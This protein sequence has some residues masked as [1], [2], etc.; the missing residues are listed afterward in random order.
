MK[1]IVFH[2]H[3]V[4]EKHP[5]GKKIASKKKRYIFSKRNTSPL[6]MEA[7]AQ[8]NINKNTY[9]MYICSKRRISYTKRA[10]NAS[11][12][13]RIDETIVTLYKKRSTPRLVLT[14]PPPPLPPNPAPRPAPFCCNKIAIIR[15][16]PTITSRKR[17]TVFNIYKIFREFMNK[18]SI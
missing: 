7:V 18:G 5:Y 16:S 14:T 3:D 6:Y 8:K 15:T 4:Q 11:T 10:R 17:I 13:K 2:A 1:E 12:K 9:N